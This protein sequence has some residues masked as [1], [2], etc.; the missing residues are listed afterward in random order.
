MN[1]PYY[2]I[3]INYYIAL[4]QT[5]LKVK[6]INCGSDT[7]FS[8]W[9]L[10]VGK[11]GSSKSLAKTIIRYK[12]FRNTIVGMHNMYVNEA[13]FFAHQLKIF[14]MG[15]CWVLFFV[16]ILWKLND[17]EGI[18]FTTEHIFWFLFGFSCY[19]F[20]VILV[21]WCREATLTLHSSPTTSKRSTWSLSSA[22][23]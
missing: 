15:A 10:I 1:Y 11:P 17:L 21:T 14:K 9:Y 13:D 19:N 18:H 22:L 4:F 8:I 23:T 16:N 12:R 7:I 3:M 6:S 5:Q 2:E 20:L